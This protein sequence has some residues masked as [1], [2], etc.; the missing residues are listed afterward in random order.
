MGHDHQVQPQSLW[1][2]GE[3]CVLRE[4]TIH[5]DW[6]LHGVDDVAILVGKNVAIQ[7]EVGRG[8]S[9]PEATVPS[10]SR[11]GSGSPAHRAKLCPED[12]LR[13]E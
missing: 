6:W 1:C 9:R 13:E 3:K 2:S 12:W 8:G 11:L 10:V 7:L 4:E 5:C